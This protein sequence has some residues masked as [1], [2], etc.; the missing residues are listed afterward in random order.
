MKQGMNM[1]K[2]M[3]A[4]LLSGLL[5]SCGQAGQEIEGFDSTAWKQDAQGCGTARAGMFEA[6]L[7][8]KSWLVTLQEPEIRRVFGKPDLVEL[9][10]RSQKFYLYYI[11]PGGQCGQGGG[12]GRM[13]EFSLDALGRAHEVNL[14]Q[15]DVRQ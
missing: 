2:M 14:R 8:S 11:E 13:L 4:V 7:A 1:R 15:P 5:A 6:V 10:S 12:Q 3:T 9:F